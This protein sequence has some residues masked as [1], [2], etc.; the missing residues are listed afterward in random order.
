MTTKTPEIPLDSEPIP[1]TSPCT[2]C[3]RRCGAERARG[4]HGLCGADD[5]ILV[6]RAALHFWEEPVLSG[7]AGSGAVFFVNCPLRCVFCQN[8]Q[9]AEGG[10]G[11]AVSTDQLADVFLSL[12]QQGALNINCVT[13]TH[14]SL[15]VR[16]A[17]HTARARGLALPVVWN[18]SGYERAATVRALQDTV[19]VYLADFKYADAALAKRYSHAP[20]YPEVALA[21]LE[22]ML[23]CTG[24]PRFDERDGLPRMTGGVIVRHLVL[25]GALEQSKRALRM[26]FERFGNAVLYSIMN[27]YTPVLPP[28]QCA[29]FPELAFRVPDEDYDRLLDFA[30]ALGMDDYFWQQGPAAEESF[31]PAWDGT[32]LPDA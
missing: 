8:A 19:D 2:L 6:A 25:P 26:L 18:T 3:P 10:A 1:R 7:R 15:Q 30:D 21:A 24:Q 11:R 32:G 28:A 17:V 14:Y 9:I 16:D 20:D 22:Q 12:Q 23:L 31:I 27:Q 13:P 29:R 4:R 5:R